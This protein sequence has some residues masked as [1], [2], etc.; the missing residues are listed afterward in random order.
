M[1][2][3]P[4]A[5]YFMPFFF[6]TLS[7]TINFSLSPTPAFVQAPMIAAI[8]ATAS[9]LPASF[10]PSSP[11]TEPL[12]TWRSFCMEHLSPSPLVLCATAPQFL[13]EACPDFQTA[14][15]PRALE[16]NLDPNP[17]CQ[18]GQVAALIPVAWEGTA[19]LQESGASASLTLTCFCSQDNRNAWKLGQQRLRA[20]KA[21]GPLLPTG[22]SCS[23]KTD[24]HSCCSRLPSPLPLPRHHFSVKL[25]HSL[26]HS[27]LWLPPNPRFWSFLES[28]GCGHVCKPKTEAIHLDT[29]E[30]SSAPGTTD[31]PAEKAE[32]TDCAW[33]QITPT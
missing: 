8:P 13:R 15:P 33:T 7:Q 5:N 10:P 9:Q 11:T 17:G 22:S 20:L 18:C 32:Q 4:S 16:S 12:R 28:E 14:G 6:L 3:D 2:I 24:L 25:F 30:V 23:R 31:L 26:S 29:T 21:R 1:A 19:A 27:R